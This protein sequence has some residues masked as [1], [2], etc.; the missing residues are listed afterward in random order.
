[1]DTMRDRM[2]RG[3]AYRADDPQLRAD[4]GRAQELLG[5]FNATP[6]GARDERGRLLGE[7]CRR[8]GQGVEVMPPFRCDYGA[9]ITI[10]PFT[11]VNYDCIFLDVAEI[12]I[13]AR[14]QIGPRVQLVC[15]MHPL[16]PEPRRAGWESGAPITLGD[17]VWLGAGAI[18]LPGVSIGED[19]VVGAGA[20]V[21]RDVPAGVAVWG[22]PARHGRDLGR[23]GG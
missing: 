13:G 10:G 23:A 19:A 2:R 9:Q 18:V 22:V 3:E 12:T 21:T 6:H 7:L 1:M 11:F 14:C 4:Y 8:V 5:R 16:A 15:A 20:V 17:N